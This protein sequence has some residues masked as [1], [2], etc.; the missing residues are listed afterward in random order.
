MS[1]VGGRPRK[2]AT[3]AER[4][5]AHKEQQAAYRQRQAMKKL[6][7]DAKSTLQ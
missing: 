7:K 2:Y 5:A 1:N 6:A 4:K 3:E